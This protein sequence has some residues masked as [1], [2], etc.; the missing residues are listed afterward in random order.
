MG[1]QDAG[2]AE[3]LYVASLTSRKDFSFMKEII[4][5]RNG[6]KRHLIVWLQANFCGALLTTKL[7]KKSGH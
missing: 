1:S 3:F 6:T 2:Q 5:M 4:N 7:I